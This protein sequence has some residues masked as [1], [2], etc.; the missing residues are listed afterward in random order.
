[1]RGSDMTTVTPEY[2][3]GQ[4]YARNLISNFGD[5]AIEELEGRANYAIDYTDFDKGILDVVRE[6]PTK[7]YYGW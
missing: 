3:R 2:Q 4:E 6:H 7:I 1:M 5:S